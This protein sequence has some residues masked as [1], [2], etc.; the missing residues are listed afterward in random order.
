MKKYNTHGDSYSHSFGG[1]WG[2]DSRTFITAG[3]Q[4]VTC[5]NNNNNFKINKINE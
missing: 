5:G 4:S 2:E 1:G 3:E